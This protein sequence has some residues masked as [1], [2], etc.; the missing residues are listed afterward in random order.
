MVAVRL[1]CSN[2]VIFD[3]IS[4]ALRADRI[5]FLERMLQLESVPTVTVPAVAPSQSHHGSWFHA[6]TLSTLFFICHNTFR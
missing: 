2:I 6:L 4:S 1:T 3:S 5:L